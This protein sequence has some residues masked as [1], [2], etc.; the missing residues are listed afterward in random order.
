MRIIDFAD[1]TTTVVSPLGSTTTAGS[2]SPAFCGGA[3][4]GGPAL[5]N[6]ARPDDECPILIIVLLDDFV[7]SLAN[8]RLH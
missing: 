7:G 5:S 1:T 8:L 2:E 4:T 3:P 6:P